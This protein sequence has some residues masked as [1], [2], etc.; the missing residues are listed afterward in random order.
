MQVH[1]H[2]SFLLHMDEHRSTAYNT[3]FQFWN[4]TSSP[5][6]CCYI[7]MFCFSNFANSLHASE[8]RHGRTF[9]QAKGETNSSLVRYKP[10]NVRETSPSGDLHAITG[11]FSSEM[12]KTISSTPTRILSPLSSEPTTKVRARCPSRCIQI[13]SFKA[14]PSSRLPTTLRMAM[15]P[16][17]IA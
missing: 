9:D 12:Y 4:I 16:V 7:I 13:L 5:V 6:R 15:L 14:L 8:H 17:S 1:I 11:E 3:V 10:L 2:T